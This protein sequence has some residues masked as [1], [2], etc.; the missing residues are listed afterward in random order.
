L[1]QV[2]TRA[3]E[4][5][6]DRRRK[7]L[8]KERKYKMILMVMVVVLGAASVFIY[9]KN[10]RDQD[11]NFRRAIRKAIDGGNSRGRRKEREIKRGL[12]QGLFY[13]SQDTK[14]KRGTKG[15]G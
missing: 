12:L 15:H 7:E 1:F 8:S 9:N 2:T 10:Q 11:N 3:K 4:N 14:R 13:T 6:N 5:Y